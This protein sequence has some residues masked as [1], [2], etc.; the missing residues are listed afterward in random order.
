MT[1]TLSRRFAA[2]LACLTTVIIVGASSQPIGA[3]GCQEECDAAVS[4]CANSCQY[5]VVDP[6]C[7]GDP[8]CISTCQSSCT[9]A[10]YACSMGRMGC[11]MPHFCDCALRAVD[12][13]ENNCEVFEPNP[14]I[15]MGCVE[16]TTWM[17]RSE[18]ECW[19]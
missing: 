12:M 13:G 4:A 2:F 8:T 15:Y 7:Q 6:N 17:A 16:W 14:Y 1:T 9:D 10:W 18:C 3:R 19:S 11:D 5:D